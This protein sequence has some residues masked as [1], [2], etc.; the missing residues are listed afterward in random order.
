MTAALRHGSLPTGNEYHTQRTFG[1]VFTVEFY[2]TKEHLI[3][4]C[5]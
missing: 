2:V 4:Y 1:N 3:F 5:T